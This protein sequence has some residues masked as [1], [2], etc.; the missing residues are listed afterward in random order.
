MVKEE[1]SSNSAFGSALTKSRPD[2]K[3]DNLGFNPAEKGKRRF[4]DAFYLTVD[5]I[6]VD[7]EQVRREG[8]S[9]DDPETVALSESI[10]EQGLQQLIVVRYLKP[11]DVYQ[12][13]S[14][15]RR[16]VAMAELLNWTEIPVRLVDVP[17]S[18]V[19]WYQLHENLIRKSLSP[20]DL[21]TAI[22]NAKSTGMSLRNIA[23]KLKRSETWV[24]KTLTIAGKLTDVALEEL[25]SG[26]QA[27]SLEVMYSVATAPKADQADIARK[28]NEQAL[29]SR[30]A[31]SLV[32]D[33]KQKS[34]E[35]G[36]RGRVATSKPF[37]RCF[38]DSNG[39]TITIRAA[40]SEVSDAELL[41]A[42]RDVIDAVS[43]SEGTKS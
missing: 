32:A 10:R 26:P 18:E 38:E 41:N 5:R 14:G 3:A 25:Q 15:E 27:E 24:Q 23:K 1:Q 21:A 28:I 2:L 36:G 13:V 8:K 37:E 31:R 16:F 43:G 42:L 30:E 39:L 19:M 9:A 40:R 22:E 12:V 4:R 20:H 17:E 29:G 35:A 7:A 11:D 33:Y 34:V 6:R